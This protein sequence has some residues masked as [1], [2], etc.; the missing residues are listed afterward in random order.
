MA[1]FI[2]GCDIHHDRCCSTAP[3]DILP[4]RMVQITESINVYKY[5]MRQ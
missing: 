3:V 2:P 1:V 5:L 4:E